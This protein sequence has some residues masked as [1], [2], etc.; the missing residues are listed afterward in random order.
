MPASMHV[1]GTV[2]TELTLTPLHDWDGKDALLASADTVL[3]A[4]IKR[5]EKEWT[6]K[7]SR[8][9]ALGVIKQLAKDNGPYG[10][11]ATVLNDSHLLVWTFA[12]P[13]YAMS[14]KWITE[15]FFVR[16]GKGSTKLALD[17]IDLLASKIGATATVMATSLAA[18]DAAL[19]RLYGQSGYSPMSSQHIKFYT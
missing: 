3:E 6:R 15:H 17:A 18:N 12:G 7:L 8:E 4:I 11:Q 16:I 5:A 9:D 1:K 2:D 13:W 10:L 19:G 14:E